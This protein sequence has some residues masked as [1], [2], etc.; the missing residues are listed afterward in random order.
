MPPMESIVLVGL[1]GTGKSTVGRPLAARLGRD[2][3]D[4]DEALRADGTGAD[5][6]AAGTGATGLHTR[7]AA[8]LVAALAGG[9][10]VIG[11]AAAVVLDPAA[12]GALRGAFVVWLRA[13][14]PLLVDRLL[15]DPSDRPFL[16]GGRAGITTLLE[17]QS[18]VRSPL[19]AGVAD[20][21][22]D[23]DGKSP[24]AIVGEVVDALPREHVPG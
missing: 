7:E 23:V 21:T 22:V 11:A 6:I 14:V 9:H 2:Y 17:E 19:Y 20:L 4:S 16:A 10:G 8:N 12:L 3:W 15:A 24:A 1:M 5:R 13:S 18:R